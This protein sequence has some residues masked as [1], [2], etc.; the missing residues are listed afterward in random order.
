MSVNYSKYFSSGIRYY[1][2]VIR[3]FEIFCSLINKYTIQIIIEEF[4]SLKR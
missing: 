2:C 1:I 4:K 3:E